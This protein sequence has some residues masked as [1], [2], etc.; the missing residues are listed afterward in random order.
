LNIDFV[1]EKIMIPIL[2][3]MMASPVWMFILLC[4]YKLIKGGRFPHWMLVYGRS[5][6]NRFI[7][8]SEVDAKPIQDALCF[9]VLFILP[10][11]VLIATH[12][13]N[14][15][16]ISILYVFVIP[17]AWGRCNRHPAA[18]G[19]AFS[20]YLA[21]LASGFFMALVSLPGN[22]PVLTLDNTVVKVGET[23]VSVLQDNGFE[24][25]SW[26]DVASMNASKPVNNKNP[27]EFL[28]KLTGT[29]PVYYE[30]RSHS[31]VFLA[32]NGRIY[33]WVNPY[34]PN[35]K[36]AALKDSLIVSFDTTYHANANGIFT[37]DHV[38]I[39]DLPIT[40]NGV[41][42]KEVTKDKFEP[43]YK[44]HF[45]WLGETNLLTMPKAYLI[46]NHSTKYQADG[47]SVKPAGYSYSV[48]TGSDNGY[49]ILFNR[50]YVFFRFNEQNIIDEFYVEA[51]NMHWE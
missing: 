49:P 18:A 14:K 12:H 8:L 15:Y 16:T 51:K 36:E 46:A 37:R 38:D 30:K 23:K 45:L 5:T 3:I 47:L 33:G 35:G 25:Y 2:L 7:K 31:E 50:Y 4:Y 11:V 40:I 6:M 26:K 9:A 48:R 28:K 42:L 27:E 1:V 20:F 13:A 32:K 34:P 39:A 44:G 43:P 29:E 17:I 24:L 41:P 22:M 19:V 10:M 21:F